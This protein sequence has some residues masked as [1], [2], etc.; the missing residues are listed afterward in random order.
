MARSTCR[1]RGGSCPPFPHLPHARPAPAGAH[2]P[3][4]HLPGAHLPGAH[5][6]EHPGYLLDPAR[7]ISHEEIRI[8]N[9]GVRSIYDDEM[10]IRTF[11]AVVAAPGARHDD[12]S[13]E[14]SARVGARR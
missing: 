12:P 3:S 7:C 8:P 10:R 13:P 2:L 6:P 11:V 1:T 14:A 5:P 4:A 9:D